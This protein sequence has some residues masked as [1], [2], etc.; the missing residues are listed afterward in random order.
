[1]KF[2][3]AMVVVLIVVVQMQSFVAIL[4]ENF[5]LKENVSED[6]GVGTKIITIVVFVLVD[7]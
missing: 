4:V 3:T 1:M 7:V 2:I 6:H 5:I